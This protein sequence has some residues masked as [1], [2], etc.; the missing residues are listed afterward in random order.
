MKMRKLVR[1]TMIVFVLILAFSIGAGPTF[2][3]ESKYTVEILDYGIYTCE[4]TGISQDNRNITETNEVSNVNFKKQ[5]TE[6]EGK[7]GL[8][9]GIL[10]K[11]VGPANPIKVPGEMRII[12]PKLMTD[13]KT[14]KS[15]ER[16]FMKRSYTPDEVTYNGYTFDDLW[17][18]IPGVWI[19]EVWVNGQKLA[20]KSFTVTMP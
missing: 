6:I 11:I 1:A 14:G 7:L 12:F 15:S 18:I 19:F 4:A 9:F 17:E 13:P 10:Y 16:F 2:A 8:S 20:E 5:T 3:E